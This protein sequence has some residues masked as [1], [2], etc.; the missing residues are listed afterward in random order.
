M[1]VNRKKTQNPKTPNFDQVIGIWTLEWESKNTL[2]AFM[3]LL[4]GSDTVKEKTEKD[5]SRMA[6][7]GMQQLSE[8]KNWGHKEKLKGSADLI[9]S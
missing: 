7:T 3:F 6:D 5:A 2:L 8:G 9:K 4:L 1:W